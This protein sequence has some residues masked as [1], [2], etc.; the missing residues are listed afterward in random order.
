MN[1]HEYQGKAILKEYGV[2]V[3]EGIVVSEAN[4]NRFIADP[5]EIC[6]YLGKTYGIGIPHD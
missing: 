6:R 4:Q 5:L 3:P 2:P 1:L